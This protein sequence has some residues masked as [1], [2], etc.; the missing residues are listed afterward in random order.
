LG[1]YSIHWIIEPVYDSIDENS[2]SDEELIP[3]RKNS[4]WGFIN[5][6]GKIAIEPH[7]DYALTFSEGL[8]GVQIMNKWGYIDST[9]QIIIQPQFDDIPGN[10][11]EGIARI[12]KFDKN[13]AL[14]QDSEL[15]IT[16]SRFGYADREGKI[17]I[18]P[19]YRQAYDFSEGLAAV[20]RIDKYGYID[21]EGE[22]VTDFIFD[23]A[24]SFYKNR[25][26]V[27]FN[28]KWGIIKHPLYNN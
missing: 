23:H 6:N 18:E 28:G 1:N 2:L 27:S 21:K 5:I 3:V 11:K 22:R 17:V 8:A 15:I 7:F 26:I 9:G 4:K 19:Q 24:E 16:G 13:P 14:Y 10:F 25:A 20:M 12:S